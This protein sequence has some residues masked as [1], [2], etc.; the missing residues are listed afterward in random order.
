MSDEKNIQEQKIELLL[1]EYVYHRASIK[2]M[3]LDLEKIREKIDRI[4]PDQ[5]DQRYMRFFEEKVKAVTSL[6]TSLLEMRKEIAKSV[7]DEI[8][9]RRRMKESDELIDIEDMVDIRQMVS[10]IDQFQKI[11]ETHQE[12][13]IKENKTKTLEGIDIPG[14]T[15][16]VEGRNDGK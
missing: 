2:E 4:I 15:S 11:K 7:K 6:F 14:I 3:I 5:L 8:D 12:K 13:R 1:E 16:K 9:I 10:K